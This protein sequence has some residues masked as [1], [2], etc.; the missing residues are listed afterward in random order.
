MSDRHELD[1]EAA[2]R[3]VRKVRGEWVIEVAHCVHCERL[4]IAPQSDE[5][6]CGA[7]MPR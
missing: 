1:D 7:E 5:C 6:V 3:A 4:V 2:A